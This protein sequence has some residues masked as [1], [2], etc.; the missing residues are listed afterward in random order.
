MKKL[1]LVLASASPRR[2]ELLTLLGVPFTVIVTNAEEVEK[3][4]PPDIVAALPP[5]PLPLEH[6]PTLLAWHKV[7]AAWLQHSHSLRATPNTND[8]NNVVLG[9]DTVVALDTAVLNKPRDEA[10]A[11]AMLAQLSGRV[12]T[13]YTGLCVRSNSIVNSAHANE[14]NQCPLPPVSSQRGDTF[15][16][17]SSSNVTIAPL[18]PDT[19]ADYVATGE[20]M[21]KAGAYGI[22]GLGGQL[23]L[24]VEGSYTCVVGLPLPATWHLLTAAGVDR[25]QDP[26]TAYYMWL[27]AQKKEPFPCPPT[28]P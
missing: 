18:Q 22:Q 26:T 4:T 25:L 3:T 5:C 6:H 28:L 15:F 16:H 24:G 11:R 7:Q 8:T 12:H 23:V 17:L 2:R 27:D 21:D 10:D 13:V 1:Q 20:P 19:I 14:H 9:A